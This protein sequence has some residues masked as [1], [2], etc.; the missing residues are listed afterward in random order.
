VALSLASGVGASSPVSQSAALPQPPGL[1]P[2]AALS[3]EGCVQPYAVGG[4]HFWWPLDERNGTTAAEILSGYNG[5]HSGAPTHV[6]AMVDWGLSFDGVDDSVTVANNVNLQASTLSVDTWIWVDSFPASGEDMDIITKDPEGAAYSTNYAFGLT[7]VGSEYH[8]ATH[9][10]SNVFD[11]TI[12]GSTAIQLRTWYHIAVTYDALILKYFINGALVDEINA[13]YGYLY[14]ADE[15]VRIGGGAPAGQPQ[16]FFHGIIDELD[17][18]SIGLID[19]TQVQAIYTAGAAGICKCLKPAAGL[20][21]WWPGDGPAAYG[22]LGNGNVADIIGDNNGVL[23]GNAQHDPNGMV[24][25]KQA[26]YFPPTGGFVEVADSASLNPADALT[27]NAW[28]W[29]DSMPTTYMDVLGKDP[30]NAP[31]AR[32]YLLTFAKDGDHAH[33]RAHVTTSGSNFIYFTGW[34]PFTFGF[35]YHVAMTYDGATLRLFVAG[36]EINNAAATGSIIANDGP[37]RIGGGAPVGQSQW[38]FNGLIDEVQLHNVA[39]SAAQ[40]KEIYDY[41][42]LGQCKSLKSYLPLVRK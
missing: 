16:H 5:T 39:L 29:F 31:G 38:Y 8:L 11:S 13:P 1:P 9:L 27:L 6:P 18:Y 14:T 40:I 34:Y 17:V 21:S 41:G 35:W 2:P 28:V 33:L 15:P 10:Q 36:T 32:Q 25:L 24:G 26:L 30:E 37:F 42:V 20:V 12:I 23:R 19:G 22:R 4:R 7:K 3:P